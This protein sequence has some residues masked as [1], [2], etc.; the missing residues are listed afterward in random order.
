[1]RCEHLSF[2]H[3][4]GSECRL[5]GVSVPADCGSA[6]GEMGESAACTPKDALR[7]AQGQRA[8]L[9]S[10]GPAERDAVMTTAARIRA[11]MESGE[12]QFGG[13]ESA[14]RT[15]RNLDEMTTE[16]L[17]ALAREA[18]AA[19][20]QKRKAERMA[21]EIVPILEDERR[22]LMER[23]QVVGE[24]LERG[25]AGKPVDMER[26]KAVGVVIRRQRRAKKGAAPSGGRSGQPWTDKELERLRRLKQEGMKVPAIAR[27]LG[28]TPQ[29]CYQALQRVP[30][31]A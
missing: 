24:Q 16:E 6:R 29:A 23:L 18:D 13:K 8:F 9:V 10:L 26:L 22:G 2:D 17:E 27:E 19:A 30:A 3:L 31:E 21:A 1:M 11:R 25:R 5:T 4:R 14:V 15:T 7:Y 28:R 20:R 12:L